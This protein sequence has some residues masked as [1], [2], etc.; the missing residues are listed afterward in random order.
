MWCSISIFRTP[1]D[2]MESQTAEFAPT[3]ARLRWT[4]CG[5]HP[6]RLQREAGSVLPPVGNGG[7]T[8][9]QL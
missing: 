6:E 2:L 4:H 3:A 1:L 8:P 7:M 9:K 5:I